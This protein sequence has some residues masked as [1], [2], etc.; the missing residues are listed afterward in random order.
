MGT[1]SP[2]RSLTADQLRA[3]WF[4]FF[5]ERGHVR[6]PS[7]SLVPESDPTLLFTGAGMNQFKEYFAGLVPPPY[8]RATTIQKCFRQGDL[9][10]V[11][12]TPRHL[13]FFEMLGHFSFGDY[14]K[15]EA[16]AWA[17]EFL[18]KEMGAP[19]DLLWVSV[20]EQ[21][22]EAYDAW[23]KIGVPRERIARFGAD[24]NFWPADAPTKGPDGVCGPCSEV[25]FDYGERR[26]KGD[27]G[28]N[29]FDS[30][31]FVEIWNSV[32]TQF[33]RRGVNDL[34]P[35]PQKNIDCGVGFERVLAMIEGQYSVFT[36]SLFRPIVEAVSEIS[37]V[38][39]PFLDNGDLPEGEGPRRIRRIADHARASC[40]LVADGVRPSNE[41]RGYVLRRVLRR[42]IGDGIQLGL[43]D[44]FLSALVDPVLQVMAGG[45]PTLP[46]GAEVFRSVFDTEEAQ[47]RRTYEQGVRFLEVETRGMGAGAVL[48]G[49]Q[50]FKLYD[51]YGFPVDLAARLLASRGVTIDQD[52]FQVAMREQQERARA[53]SKIH[54]AI[55]VGG[56]LSDLRAREVQTTEFVGY[57]RVEASARVVGLVRDGA[58]VDTIEAGD[59]VQVILDRTPFYAESGGQ[60][61]DAGT[62]TVDGGQVA[63]RDT[64]AREAYVLHEGA[65]TRG[66]METG[67]E[68]QVVV[69]DAKRDATRRNHT[70]THLLHA[71]LRQI[72]GESVR[73]EGSLVA[74]DHL[75]FDFSHPQAMAEAEIEEVE[76]LVNEWI[77]ANDEVST[78]TKPLDEAKASG[79]TSLF[80]EKYDDLVRVVSVES[81]SSELC[82]GTHAR[83]PGDIGAFRLTQ[84]TAVAAGV[85]RIEAVTGFG[86]VSLAARDRRLVKELSTTFK[87][88]P[89]EILERVEAL[90]D[91]V[92][93]LRKAEERGRRDAGLA[94]VG[95]LVETAEDLGG[96]RVQA[97]S[98]PGVDGKALRGIWDGLKQGGVDVAV[99][100][101]E[102]GGKAPLLVGLSPAAVERGL[103]ARALLGAATEVLGG[104]GGGRPDMAQGQGQDAKRRDEALAQA[105]EALEAALAQGGENRS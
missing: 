105:R 50:A 89:D 16:I 32:F 4:A 93:S 51:T 57:D 13:T 74:P 64:Q 62:L 103:D 44:P 52:G 41:G 1:E 7:D 87:V 65:V 46:E 42:A 86:A 96:L 48:S 67:N 58:L 54:G 6:R 15:T 26:A 100:I 19:A 33:D 38:E 92:K 85:R 70:A 17:W 35:L 18:T 82:G 76:R 49:A 39:H 71:A 97:V 91:E 102:A 40:F 78:E 90:K 31:R 8:R 101:G 95:R 45:Y 63:V 59:R 5:E 28:S 55:F 27:G 56:P 36:T 80:G 30:G 21:D 2:F 24:E 69:D 104:R 66:R 61:G 94:A 60:V 23:R 73:Q 77:L 43:D 37:G 9:D 10:H 81:G 3:A 72:L 20:Y 25:Y 68:V 99:V 88:V 79:A 22:D 53:G 83:R 84:E 34:V 12:R 75:R 29:E 47:F 11:G 14:F 98:L